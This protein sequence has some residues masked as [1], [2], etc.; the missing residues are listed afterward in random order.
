MATGSRFAAQA[1][2]CGDMSPV[3]ATA[4][5]DLDTRRVRGSTVPKQ[6]ADQDLLDEVAYRQSIGMREITLKQFEAEIRRIGYRFDRRMDCRGV[7]RYMTG[8]RSGKSHP[9]LAL[10]PVQVSDGISWCS[11]YARR[12][13]DFKRLKVLRESVYAVVK[14]AIAEF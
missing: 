9:Y 7:S 4:L 14:G 8:P 3:Q 1:S 2:D 11:V 10:K 13:D 5:C 6:P 12:D